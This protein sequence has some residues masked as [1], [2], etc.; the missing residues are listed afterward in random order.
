MKITKELITKTKKNNREFKK[1]L[2]KCNNTKDLFYIL[3]SLGQLPSNFKF[4]TLSHLLQHDNSQIRYLTV[5]NLGKVATNGHGK[6]F[7]NLIRNEDNSYVRREAV[8]SLGRMRDYNNVDFLL[9][10]L[11]DND[12]NIT[13]QAI[14]A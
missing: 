2:K 6:V 10:L 4:A 3:K 8:S 13:L 11:N 7:R 14:R 12:P 1:L 9:A 5:K